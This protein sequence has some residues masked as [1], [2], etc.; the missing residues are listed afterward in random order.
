MQCILSI[1]R[2]KLNETLLSSKHLM[3][4]LVFVCAKK[5][6]ELLEAERSNVTLKFLHKLTSLELDTGKM[7]FK[8]SKKHWCESL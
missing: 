5:I 6:F 7:D 8:L 2:R 3:S 1:D 4:Q